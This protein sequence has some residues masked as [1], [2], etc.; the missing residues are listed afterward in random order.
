MSKRSHAMRTHVLARLVLGGMAIAAALSLAG[1]GP[2]ASASLGGR[3]FLSTAV[4]DGGQPKNLVPGTRVRLGFADANITASAG[5][6]TIGGTYRIDG[7][8]LVVASLGMTDMGCDPD[9]QAQDQWLIALLNAGPAVQLTGDELVLQGDGKLLR[10]LDRRVADPDRPLVGTR[11]VLDSIVA[12]DAVSSVPDAVTATLVF[13][14]DGTVAVDTGCNRGSTR[15]AATGA[16]L[17]FEGLEVTTKGCAAS[18]GNVENAV[19]RV[20]AQGTVAASI[21][22]DVLSLRAGG[23]GLDYRAR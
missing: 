3:A 8:R 13:K 20:L 5:C 1:C 17:R 23:S 22:A 4:T 19:T 21:R 14:D 9:R 7:G 10:L 16:G 11:W 12:G 6:N 15:W 2:T 18:L